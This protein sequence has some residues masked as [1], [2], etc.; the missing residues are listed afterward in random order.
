[1]PSHPFGESSV[2]IDIK[3]QN[4]HRDSA[5]V[6]TA[7]RASHTFVIPADQGNSVQVCVYTGLGIVR[8]Q[9]CRTWTANG[10]DITVNQSAP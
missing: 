6:G 5:N 9:N 10:N 2:N 3:T 1:V 7:G 8:G 4:G